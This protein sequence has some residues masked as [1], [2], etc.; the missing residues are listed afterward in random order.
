MSRRLYVYDA[1]HWKRTGEL[2]QVGGDWK[3]S[4]RNDAVNRYV[5]DERLYG[6]AG[7]ATDGAAIDSRT[8]HKRYMKE[9]GLTTADDFKESWAAAEKERERV[10]AFGTDPDKAQ[11]YERK[12]DRGRREAVGRAF[13]DVVGKG[14]RFQ[15]GAA[16]LPEGLM[17][18]QD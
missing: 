14:K 1:A 17:F 6:K 3:P 7:R 16:P 9:R 10:R 4:H 18:H 5:E 2:L 11:G 15:G 12:Y 8:K 13:H